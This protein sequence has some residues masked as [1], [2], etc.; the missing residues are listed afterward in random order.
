MK[1]RRMLNHCPVV[2]LLLTVIV[3]AMMWSACASTATVARPQASQSPR[4]GAPVVETVLVEKPEALSPRLTAT[5]A[6]TPMAETAPSGEGP[7]NGALPALYRV[8]RM[9]IKNAEVSL[10]VEDTSVAIDGVTQVAADTFGYILSSRTWYEGPH[11]HATITIGV[12]TNEFENAMR[13]IRGLGVRVEDEKASGTDVTD[14]YVDLE[15]RLRNLE[16]TEARIRSFM[17]KATTV[18]E[19]LQVNARLA[20][21]GAQIEQIKGQ[22]NYLQDRSAYSTITVHLL[23]QVPT[24][25]PTPTPTPV[26]DVWRPDETF[27]DASGVLGS[28][29]RSLGDMAIWVSVVFG[30]FL[31]PVALVL[32]LAIRSHRRS[33]R[34]E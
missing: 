8:N 34:T 16:A 2:P 4:K 19:S 3:G 6:P 11:Q 5:P 30:P 29:A 17:E 15:S 10:L 27:R 28:I 26:P 14:Q 23:P 7:D 9:I 25:T 12:P 20:D 21:I 1:T 32:W 18:E 13:R 33:R 22:M 31:L 24:P